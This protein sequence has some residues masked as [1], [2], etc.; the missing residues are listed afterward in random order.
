MFDNYNSRSDFGESQMES[1]M[2]IVQS[3]LQQVATNPDLFSHVF[4]DKAN[5]TEFHSARIQWA[6]GDFSQLPSVE[7]LPA[8][9][10]DGA[11]GAYSNSTQT[12]Y[13]S[14]S[15]FEAH[16]NSVFGAAG[17]LVEEV[18]HWLDD[19]IQTDYDNSVLH[20]HG[21][22]GV[23]SESTSHQYEPIQT[24]KDIQ[25]DENTPNSL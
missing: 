25:L 1:V 24:D 15:L 4:G 14:D 18:F 13:L 7:V 6:S 19:R 10:M 17:V 12:I 16:A 5:T 11:D 8:S 9:S 20:T 2:G 22:F 23:S 3:K 21:A